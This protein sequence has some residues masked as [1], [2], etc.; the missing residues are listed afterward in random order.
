MRQALLDSGLETV[1]KPIVRGSVAAGIGEQMEEQEAARNR[2]H[3]PERE[4]PLIDLEARAAD[5]G[6]AATRGISEILAPYG[7]FAVD[8][9]L[10]RACMRLG[11]ECNA[12]QLADVVP[13][14]PS[15][16]SRIVT[17]LVDM[18][19]LSRRRLR[20][21]RR[22]VMLRL[23]DEGSELTAQLTEDTQ[24]YYSGLLEGIAEEDLRVFEAIVA[25]ITENYHRLE[26][27]E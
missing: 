24:A 6:I 4:P 13:T 18:G 19:L 14:D 1:A 7:L 27:A 11:S 15:R 25:R 17:K 5:L 9:S 22:I 26:S 16:I 10:L 12:T 20:N 3:G 23:T 8:F 21:D 2:A